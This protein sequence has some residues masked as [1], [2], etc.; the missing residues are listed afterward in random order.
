MLSEIFHLF[1][2]V[3]YIIAVLTYRDDSYYEQLVH[4]CED[5]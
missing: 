1:C 4:V 3:V 5:I 2:S